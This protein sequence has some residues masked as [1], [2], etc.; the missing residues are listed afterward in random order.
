MNKL[1]FLSLSSGSNG[2][3]Y[4]LGTL[5]R[6][7]LIDAGIAARTIK[8]RLREAGLDI[9]CVMAVF[10][11][12]DHKDHIKSIAV[13]GEKYH[14]PVYATRL[15]HEGIN[16]NW[17]ITEKLDTS[18][19]FIEKGETVSVFDFTVTAFPVSHDST[20][21]VGYSVEYEGKNIVLATDLGYINEEV[22][23]HLRRAHVLII[24]A[25]YDER[26]LRQGSYP[27][28]LQRRIRGQRGHLCND[29]TAAFLAGNYALHWRFIFLCHL[30]RDNNRPDIALQTIAVAF[31]SKGIEPDC[32]LSL[33]C[34]PRTSATELILLEWE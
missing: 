32:E 12:H 17:S 27:I 28:D 1:R 15:T 9:S 34:L 19:R 14:I 10:V 29:E 22:A 20:D 33:R 4:Y 13:L 30:S 8:K 26:M 23:G 2:N 7:V 25:N 16:R 31:A 6:G 11:T 18:R 24:E 21:S 3:S 5:Q